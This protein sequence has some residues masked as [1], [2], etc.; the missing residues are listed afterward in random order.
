[1]DDKEFEDLNKR[2][3]A[4][5]KGLGQIASAVT[6]LEKCCDELQELKADK[7]ELKSVKTTA[8]TALAMTAKKVDKKGKY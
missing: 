4:L 5:D 3:E 8:L 1:M 6:K 7:E 2:V